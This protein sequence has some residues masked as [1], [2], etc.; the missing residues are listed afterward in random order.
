MAREDPTIYM[1]I[2]Q[3]LKDA[4]DAA[5]A[6]NRRSLTAEVVARL[7]QSFS[8]VGPLSIDAKAEIKDLLREAIEEAVGER[9]A[10]QEQRTALSQDVPPTP[11][12]AEP[13]LY[14]RATSKKKASS[15]SPAN[16]TSKISKR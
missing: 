14:Q 16:T 13:S 5:A 2:P 3:D 7:Q 15:V 9:M 11:P 4:L 6:D 1:R 12:T 10:M 8:K